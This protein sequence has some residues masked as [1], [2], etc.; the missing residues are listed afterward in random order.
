[1][2]AIIE[3]IFYTGLGAA[4]LNADRFLKSLDKAS[5]E[6]KVAEEE[7]KKLVE[8]WETASQER[9]A[10]LENK[11]EELNQ[12]VKQSIGTYSNNTEDLT[13]TLE[14]KEAATA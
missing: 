8:E 5:Y 1:M 6:L 13:E 4:S 2:K 7:G 11:F 12:K 3:D 10:E 14:K 9:R